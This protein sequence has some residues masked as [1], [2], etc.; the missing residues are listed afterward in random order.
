MFYS[1]IGYW[2]NHSNPSWWIVQIMK[3]LSVWF[4]V[5]LFLHISYVMSF[6]RTSSPCFHCSGHEVARLYKVKAKRFSLCFFLC[7][8]P[9]HEGVL[10]EW[11]YSSTHFWPPHYMEVSGKLHAPGRFTSRG[12]SPWHPLDRRRGGPQSRSGHSAGEKKNPQ[13]LPGLEPPIIQPIAQ[14]YTTDLRQHT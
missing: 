4:M 6:S 14:R 13:P 11:S 9:R 12:K 7:W 5:P 3:L 1:S 10:G 8:T 2:F